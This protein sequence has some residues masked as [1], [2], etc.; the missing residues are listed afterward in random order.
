M[1]YLSEQ[2]SREV[3]VD[4]ESSPLLCNAGHSD[5]RGHLHARVSTEV[6]GAGPSEYGFEAQF[7]RCFYS[8]FGAAKA[9]ANARLRPSL[10]IVAETALMAQPEMLMDLVLENL[11]C[12]RWLR[13]GFLV[14]EM[15]PR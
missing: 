2:I 12:R 8:T 4:A 5:R 13:A 1:A 14:G 15:T 3:L 6:S 7:A 11:V 10:N 9:E